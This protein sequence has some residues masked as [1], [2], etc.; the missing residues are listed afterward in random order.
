MKTV[1]TQ[2]HQALFLIAILCLVLPIYQFSAWIVAYNS[3]SQ[4][5]ERVS[6]FKGYAFNLGSDLITQ[7]VIVILSAMALLISSLL[8]NRVSKNNKWKPLVIHTLS[9]ALLVLALWGML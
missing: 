2:S 3:V 6:I 1:S 9:W 4:H 5:T 7:W 8:L